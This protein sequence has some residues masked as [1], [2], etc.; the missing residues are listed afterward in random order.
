M[1]VAKK[2]LKVFIFIWAFIFFTI[3]IYPFFYNKE[4]QLWAIVLSV[5]FVI[6]AFI[7]PIIFLAFYKIWTKFGNFIGGIISKIIMFILYF[8]LFTPVSIV[9]KV[10]GKDLLN[11]KMNKSQVSYWIDR[12]TQPQSMKKQF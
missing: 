10:L 5:C 1:T 2:D 9:L 11:K 4:P 12:E 6:V 3:G 8:G 7:K